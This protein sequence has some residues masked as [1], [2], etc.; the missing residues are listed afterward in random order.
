[1]SNQKKYIA[2]CTACLLIGVCCYIFFRPDS[3]ITILHNRLSPHPIRTFPNANVFLRCY[4]SD[5]LWG[6]ALALGFLAIY[7]PH[8]A[9]GLFFC[10]GASA[11]LGCAWELLQ[12]LEVVGGTGDI[13]DVA[14]YLSSGLLTAIT[15][16]N[17]RIKT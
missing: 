17:E 14:M 1:M 15:N 8:K 16:R 10:C 11:L 6:M 5:F 4:L 9:I 13:V 12:Y 2:R 7:D 3:Y